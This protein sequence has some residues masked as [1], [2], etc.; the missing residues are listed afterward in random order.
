MIV[1]K[2][3]KAKKRS[4]TEAVDILLPNFGIR[5]SKK[6]ILP[7]VGEISRSILKNWAVNNQ[8]FYNIF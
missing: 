1:V 2:I 6:W 7:I 3:I 5:L 4:I 8:I